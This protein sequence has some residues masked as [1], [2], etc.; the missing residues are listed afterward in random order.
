M[1]RFA[2]A[3]LVVNGPSGA[4]RSSADLA[5]LTE[6]FHARL[7]DIPCRW[8][9][10]THDHD[11]VTG[12]TKAFL[13][14]TPG[15]HFVLAG[16]GG[17]TLRAVA[18]GVMEMVEARKVSLADTVLST[19]RLGS[20]NLVA[21][22][23]GVP[24]D[25]MTA[26]AGIA[27][28]VRR[29]RVSPVCAYRCRLENA[30]GSVTFYGL[31]LGLL[32][33]LAEVP[34]E[35]ADW[36]DRYRRLVRWLAP[37]APIEKITALQYAWGGLSKAARCLLNPQLAQ[38]VEIRSANLTARLRLLAGF[39][40]NFDHATLPFRSDCEIGEPRLQLCLL[41]YQGRRRLLSLIGGK[42]V[43]AASLLQVDITPET[44]LEIAFPERAAASLALDED[45]F[46]AHG[47]V[48]L[49][50]AGQVNFVPGS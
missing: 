35:A 37:F 24:R 9:K 16:G 49:A 18:Q 45:T 50:V 48:Q 41:P 38:W 27:E 23:L 40:V 33:L 39:L 29:E 47:T 5:A 19:L 6:V 20:G 7:S 21:R 36:K 4:G 12:Q 8:V 3:L 25:P 30:T 15:P 26:L 11:E 46:T 1:S 28:N 2:S 10:L 42:K 44:P 32:G 31:T 17:G 34:A 22:E 13:A 14:S 43:L